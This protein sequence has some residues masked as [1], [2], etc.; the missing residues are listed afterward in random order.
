MQP[1]SEARR[2]LVD[3]VLAATKRAHVTRIGF[4]GSKAFRAF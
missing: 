1:E 3:E 4:V 2:E